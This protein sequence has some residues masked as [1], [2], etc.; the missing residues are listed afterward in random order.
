MGEELLEGDSSKRDAGG[1]KSVDSLR[2]WDVLR[3]AALLRSQPGVD[4]GRITIAGGGISGTLGL[5]AA[6]LEPAIAQ[7]LLLSPPSSH[8]EGPIFLNILRYLDLP[9]AA[10]LLAPRRLNFYSHIPA[11]FEP[12]RRVYAL[13]QSGLSAPDHGYRGCCAWAVRS[14]FR[15]RAARRA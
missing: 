5:Y 12:A 3:A 4:G 2:L 10:A 14:Q 13:R 11:A 6:I 8:T 15:Q 9:E 7:V 1:T